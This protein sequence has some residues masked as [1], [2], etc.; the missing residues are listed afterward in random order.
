[1]NFFSKMLSTKTSRIGAYTIALAAVVVA[2][3]I[4]VNSIL[5]MLPEKITHI[6]MSKNGLY[7]LSTDSKVVV[8]NLTQEV[9]IYLISQAGQEDSILE[10]LMEKYADANKR[11]KYEKV[12]PDVNPTFAEKYVDEVTNNDVL[13]KSGDRY[14]YIEYSKM[15]QA[16]NSYYESDENHNQYFDGEGEITSAIDYVV[17]E[18]LPVVYFVRGHDEP[19]LEGYAETAL[20]RANVTTAPLSLM[21]TKKVPDDASCVVIYTPTSD[22]SSEDAR[23]LKEYVANGGKLFVL[24]GVAREDEFVNLNSILEEYHIKKNPGV[25]L[26]S[27]DAYY[28]YNEQY[29]LIPYPQDHDIT[30]SLIDNFKYPIFY[31]TAG[32]NIDQNAEVNAQ[33]EALYVT[34]GTAYSKLAGYNIQSYDM[35]DGDL[36]GPFELGVTLRDINGKGGRMVWLACDYILDEEVNELSSNAN[37]DLFVNSTSWLVGDR[38]TITIK[39]KA[40]NNEYLI[41]SDA[42]GNYLKVMLIGVIPGVV[43]LMGIVELILRRKR[44]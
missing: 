21:S 13:V 34:S 5:G 33:R 18:N 40:V 3:A 7:T 27:N 17:K 36:F 9:E 31:I 39:S 11:I 20:A 1:M 25:V 4:L 22:I 16:G 14:R 38:E 26:E 28:A 2:I 19:T 30:V 10:T 6:D 29:L 32:L 44:R 43:V 24:S 35:E 41:M 37:L 23:I 42:E 8:N 15:Y 12:N